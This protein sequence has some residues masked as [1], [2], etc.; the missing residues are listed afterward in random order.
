MLA[1]LRQHHDK[2]RNLLKSLEALCQERH[3]D[4]VKVSAVRLDLTRASRARSAFLNAVVYPKLLRTCPPDKRIAIE[5]LKSDGLLMLV[6]SGDHIRH[7]TTRE[8]AADWPGYCLASA[9]ARQSMIARIELEAELLY[10]LLREE[11]QDRRPPAR[12]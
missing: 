9:A 12:S 1:E 8:V 10:P 2:I 7:W 5:K 3:A 4:I 6:R 11:G